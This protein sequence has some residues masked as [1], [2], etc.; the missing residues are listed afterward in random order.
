MT[1][2]FF[3]FRE[4][5]LEMNLALP[6]PFDL[7]SFFTLLFLLKS[8][9]C[10]TRSAEALGLIGRNLWLL[11]LV[12]EKEVSER[13]DARMQIAERFASFQT[14]TLLPE[15]QRCTHLSIS[16]AKCIA[17]LRT[18]LAP[19]LTPGVFGLRSLDG[20][21]SNK[22]LQ[23]FPILASLCGCTYTQVLPILGD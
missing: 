20:G 8:T 4:W 22:A 12:H 3:P 14:G 5:K 9:P 7:G 2:K 13:N 16:A 15:S 19:S 11:V 1:A 6:L 18:T 21:G 23:R 17:T 10:F